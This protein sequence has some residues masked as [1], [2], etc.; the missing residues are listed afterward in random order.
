MASLSEITSSLDRTSA[1]VAGAMLALGALIGMSFVLG[2]KAASADPDAGEPDDVP[3]VEETCTPAADDTFC[4]AY[5]DAFCAAHLACCTD[6]DFRYESM[7]LCVQRTTCICTSFRS[8]QAAT[9]GA[10]TF[11]AEAADAVLATL[12]AAPESCPVLDDAGAIL[13]DAAFR[14]SLEEGADCSPQENDYSSLLAC[15]EGLYCYVTD[16]GDETTPPRADCRRYVTEGGE[17]DLGAECARG[18]YCAPG[19][20]IDSPGVC[21]PY[22]AAGAACE[23]DAECASDLCDEETY[24]CVARNADD[25][26]CVDAAPELPAE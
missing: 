1:G 26:W 6:P 10:I 17:C 2:C 16:F 22:L 11:D 19:A 8:G 12:T 13:A 3:Y 23:I 20:D 25:T 24:T 21:R 14:G 18:L 7:Q 5:A 9:S 4:P 15:G